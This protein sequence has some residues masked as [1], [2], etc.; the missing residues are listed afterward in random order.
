M[1]DPLI[2]ETRSSPFYAPI[3]ALHA[4]VMVPGMA[5]TKTLSG[6]FSLTSSYGSI[7]KL[8]PGGA[9]RTVTLDAEASASGMIRL[10]INAADAAEDLTVKDDATNTIGTVSQNEMALFYCD[11]SA[12]NLLAIVTIALA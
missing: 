7:V 12:W 9:G 8:D 1:A 6:A 2:T 10:I 4:L 11:G 5:T 3:D